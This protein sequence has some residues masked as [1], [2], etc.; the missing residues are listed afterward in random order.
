[1]NDEQKIAA[2]E[3][4][5]KNLTARMDDL[6]AGFKFNTLSM[7]RHIKRRD[8]DIA[9]LREGLDIAYRRLFPGVRKD[10]RRINDILLPQ[11]PSDK[12]NR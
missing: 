7:A 5:I 6:F 10:H 11:V 9:D 12:K 8:A 1:M 4:Q 3:A 2:L